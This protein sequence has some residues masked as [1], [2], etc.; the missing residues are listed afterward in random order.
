MCECLRSL[1]PE[2]EESKA[3]VIQFELTENLS[4]HVSLDT[5]YHVLL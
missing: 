2:Y 5:I 3:Q 1:E 4:W